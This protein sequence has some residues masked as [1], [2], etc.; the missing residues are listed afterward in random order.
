M[1]LNTPSELAAG[2]PVRHWLVLG[3][4]VVRT[5][6]HFD[7][8][9]MYE[10]E[11]ILDIDY[12]E[13]SGGE[14]AVQP[15]RG[16]THVNMGIGPRQL[17][18][19]EYPHADL[20]GNRIAGEI[21]YETVQRNCVIYAA[22][23]IEAEQDGL[24]VLD[25]HHSGMKVWVNGDL[26]CNEP[27]GLTKGV[28]LT[29][30]SKP[31][32][33]RRG[34]NLLLVKFRPGY[35]CDGVDFGVRHVTISPM[36]TAKGC[37]VALGRVRAL[38]YFYG[39]PGRPRQV[40]QASLLNLSEA[41]LFARA[42]V[43]SEVVDS[44]DN[45]AVECE[46]G[47]ATPVRLT[48]DA[49]EAMAG[50]RLTGTYSAEVAGHTVSMPF[51][52]EVAEAPRYDGR[53]FVP[54]SFHF[55]TTYHEEQRVYAMGA[56]DIVRQ[57]CKLHREDP[58][59]RSI[60]S[61]V[62][63]LKPYADVYPDDRET[64]FQVF[65]EGRSEPDVMYNQ[66]NEQ[67]CGGE[68]LV[69]NFL[70]GQL[71]HG[72]LFGNICRVY[73]PGDVFGHPNQLSQIA[74]KSGCI[75]V[76]WDK[77]IFNFPPVFNHLSLDGSVLPHKRG[78]AGLEDVHTTGLQVGT[79]GIDQTPPTDWH[80]ALVPAYKQGTY[81]DYM[82]AVIEECDAGEA[83]LPVTSR[84][85]AL[86]HAA[87]SLSRTNLKIANRLGENVLIAAEKFATIAALLG[88]KYPEKALD[89][90][91]RQ[92]LCGQH[93]DSIT[94]THNE[95][96]FVDLMNSYREVLELGTDVLERSLDY[97][98]QGIDASG[99]DRPLGAIAPAILL[100]V[101]NSLAW[102]RT[103]V[104][105]AEVKP[106][107]L[108][109]FAI[110]DHK[111]KQVPF[112]VTR[113]ERNK[114]G[115]VTSAEVTFVA[116]NLPSLGYRAYQIVPSEKPLPEPKVRSGTAI[117]NEFYRIEV[118][119]ARGGGI[120]SLYDKQ[121]KRE[122]LDMKS[123]HPGNELAILEEVPDRRETQHEFYTTGLKMFSSDRPAEVEVSKGPVSATLRVR[124]TMGE[125]CGVVQEITLFK[126]VRRI[127][128]RTLLLDVQ[129]EDYLYC[130]TFPTNL[131]GAVPVFDE[132][133]GVVARN[134][135]KGSLDFRT[136]RHLMFSDCAVYAANKWMEYGSTAVLEMGRN[137]YALSMVGL[138]TP[139]RKRDIELAERLQ[140]A[141]IKKGVTC[142]PWRDKNGPHW[143][144][145]QDHMDDDLPY[146]RFRIALGAAGKNAYAQKLLAA[147][148]AAVRRAYQ[149]RLEGNGYA[150]LFV[151]DGDL[152]E[153]GWAPLPVLI[154]E[155]VKHRDLLEACVDM[156]AGFEETATI[157]LPAAVDATSESHTVDNYGV[158]LLNTGTYANSVDQRGVICMML[159]HTCRWY[160]GTNNFPEGYL[161]PE[162][163]NHVY[164]YALYPH[165]GTWRE[166][167]T[168][169]AGYAFNHP[170]LARQVK[171]ART[172]GCSPEEGTRG[173]NPLSERWRE[174]SFV[175][176]APKNVILAAMKPFG[177]P[178]AGF[179]KGKVADPAA[180][181]MLRLY[182]TEGIASEARIEFASGIKA[183]WS[184]NLVEERQEDLEVT[185]GGI[186]V[187]VPAFSIET[188]G[189]V[190]DKKCEVRSAKCEVGS[191]K[192]QV[193]GAKCEVLGAEAEPVQPVWVR[194]WEHDA[195]SMP[196][197][198]GGV[199]CSM[200]REVVEEDGGRTLRLRVN[201]V[202]DYTDA[203]VQGTA[204]L[205]VPEGWAAE[206]GEIAFDMA[207][208]GY[209]SFE[210]TVR[211]PDARG[212]G[213][214]KLRHEYDGQVFQDVLEIGEAFDLDMTV[215]NELSVVSCQLSVVSRDGILVT[216]T[217][218]SAETVD[219]EVALVTPIET[220]P[221]ALVGPHAL[222]DISPRTQ[223][224]CLAPGDSTVL[225]YA[226][227]SLFDQV[228]VPEASYWAVAKMMANGRITLKRC[229]RRPPSRRLD[230]DRWFEQYQAKARRK[231]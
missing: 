167:N 70:Y 37:P 28:R 48:L 202:N 165:A 170:L 190:P 200:S 106:A 77:H 105:R 109:S 169:H 131:K 113:I 228:P 41:T 151:K 124:C 69:R 55:D 119:P 107:G 75:G 227:T 174:R 160:G 102:K 24:A 177:N 129:G 3:P 215:E 126:G 43:V 103:D 192:W 38:P 209:Q 156:L 123:R 87:T 211:R 104:V 184:A 56:F 118:D 133:F 66:P 46:P 178:M 171:P 219:A 93:H 95:I 2:R 54:T 158:A 47:M 78:H 40:I 51:E 25:A 60:I 198:Y 134:D 64:L 83:H 16:Q 5:S 74:R 138:V 142:T 136:H 149:R 144:T 147:Q 53:V 162:N 32:R 186:S 181:I 67:T 62:D 180:G 141:L 199:V 84:D 197:G 26:V 166:A 80:A 94:G 8:E 230:D 163:R 161:V 18:W 81:G 111:G 135:S 88:A 223:G 27:Y 9:Y 182:D 189:F 193:R 49:P 150:Y 145:Y 35:I 205:L 152:A 203:P 71:I 143:G 175:T 183:A 179:E 17:R 29:M 115:E 153:P 15:V 63:Y 204:K 120:V 79:G 92:I 68:A 4:F 52:W 61:E 188:V 45:M 96:S 201:A 57:Y 110:L 140:R 22:A 191:A 159:N 82:T 1:E 172:R 100:V 132:R 196:M 168:E 7:R 10:R 213:Q 157:K 108:A 117:E 185:E 137:K 58:N 212:A 114:R 36:A 154:V 122:V 14:T 89:K 146:T 23:R 42:R 86:Y 207:A 208:L 173:C 19:Q 6:P 139:N 217:N 130:V 101:F 72:R 44:K 206:P 214:I 222:L 39:D 220:W 98:G 20:H 85:M 187:R 12:L 127:E 116:R 128:F 195:E 33:L 91:W 225:H 112:E 90:A 59:F 11:H 218:S 65:R 97:L 216:L 73:G 76:S 50:E 194:S 31:L 229:D 121:A 155:G 221:A 13:P 30:P 210:V 231:R 125:L 34:G 99:T 176:V 21:I 226:V 224:V 148:S 164:H